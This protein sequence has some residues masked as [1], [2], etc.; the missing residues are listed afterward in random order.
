MTYLLFSPSVKTGRR[1]LPSPGESRLVSL[2]VHSGLAATDS[3]SYSRGGARP[4]SFFKRPL[5]GRKEAASVFLSLCPFLPGNGAANGRLL[6]SAA[7][8]SRLPA[9]LLQSG[10]FSTAS[11]SLA[12]SPAG[13]L[14]SRASPAKFNRGRGK[15]TDGTFC[16][17]FSFSNSPNLQLFSCSQNIIFPFPTS[18]PSSLPVS[19]YRSRPLEILLFLPV[20]NPPLSLLVPSGRLCCDRKRVWE[21]RGCF[22]HRKDD[23]K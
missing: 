6:T 4:P 19:P 21:V 11:P 17:F 1:R 3:W 2:P 16:S 9:V 20:A 12:L 5:G 7:P 23:R 8:C 15:V 10:P 13:A 18:P 22:C 14:P